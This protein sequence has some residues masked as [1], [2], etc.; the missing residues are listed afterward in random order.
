[1]MDSN[2]VEA[3]K[4]Q[5]KN[6]K[7]QIALSEAVTRLYNNDDF[8]KV[9]LENYLVEEK[10]RQLALSITF[11]NKDKQDL[12]IRL[13]QACSALET[14]LVRT[15]DQKSL[16]TSSLEENEQELYRIEHTEEGE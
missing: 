4:Q 12:S 14:W 11:P 8:K 16:A 9:I 1:M 13:A 6:C 2:T 3:L 15:E 5:I 7:D 10:N